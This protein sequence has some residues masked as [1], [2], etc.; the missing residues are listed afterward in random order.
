VLGRP[1]RRQLKVL[2]QSL[3][4]VTLAGCV[5]SGPGPPDLPVP[6]RSATTDQLFS[7]PPGAPVPPPPAPP[8]EI[9]SAQEGHGAWPRDVVR[10]LE[11]RA[12]AGDAAAAWELYIYYAAILHRASAMRPGHER[13]TD[14]RHPE[15]ERWMADSIR[16]GG[17]FSRYGPT[18]QAAVL[19]LLTDACEHSG[20]ACNELGEAYEEGYF[21]SPD[22]AQARV[23]QERGAELGYRISWKKL[24]RVLRDGTGGPVDLQRAYFWTSLE[25]R[26]VD[27][28]SVGGEETWKLREELAVGLELQTLEQVWREVDDYMAE[29]EAGRRPIDYDPF[30]GATTEARVRRMGIR[31]AAD[32]ERLHR[33]RLRR[34]MEPQSSGLPNKALHQTRREGAAASRPVVEARLAGEGWCY[35][36]LSWRRMR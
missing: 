13:A 22:L 28:R 30:G 33:E 4:L 15:A 5:D 26:C 9:G 19:Q 2:G 23:Y 27:P 10:R 36:G 12:A 20:S 25:A 29:H 1:L 7:A 21:G 16:R 32:K 6:F 34:E 18:A 14:L 17:S 31:L 24:A 3:L 35:A 8:G 11:R